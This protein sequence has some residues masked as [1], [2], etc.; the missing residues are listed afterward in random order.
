MRYLTTLA[1][2]VAR[3]AVVDFAPAQLDELLSQPAAY[4]F[5]AVAT[6]DKA[7]LVEECGIV[8]SD[9]ATTGRHVLSTGTGGVVDRTAKNVFLV[10][11]ADELQKELGWYLP[12]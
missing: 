1:P 2:V 7:K 5:L 12:P 3:V 6:A 11:S 4:A 10:T 9:A 8:T